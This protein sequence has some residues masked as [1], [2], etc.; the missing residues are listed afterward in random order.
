MQEIVRKFSIKHDRQ[1][2]RVTSPLKDCLGI[3]IFIYFRVEENGA[4]ATLTSFPEQLE[5]YY[6]EDLHLSNP[7]LVH[8]T[9]LSPGC[10]LTT[11]TKDPKYIETVD[12]SKNRFEMNNP[13]L[14]LEKR[15][16]A[17]EGFLFATHSKETSTISTYLDNLDLLKKYTRYFSQECQ[18]LI[19][20]M[21][22]EG[23]NL[24][25][26]KGKAFLERSQDLPLSS[27]NSASQ[28]F[29]K[30]ISPLSKREQE[31]LNLFCEGKSAQ[32]TAARLGLSRRTVEH[33]FERIKQKLGCHSKWDLLGR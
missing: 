10:V 19:A 2:K 32:A 26:E 16:N 11:T 7:Y 33:Y 23:Y 3:P 31:C 17:S 29:L 9:L 14:L 15:D 25:Q 18:P 8:P 27:K 6:H 22:R 12:L 1:I 28:N 21:L 4:F 30:A 5:Y 13:F 20:K 24:S